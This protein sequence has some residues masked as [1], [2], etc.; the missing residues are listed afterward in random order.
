MVIKGLAAGLEG[1]HWDVQGRC[2]RALE[3]LRAPRCGHI[4]EMPIDT[5]HALKLLVCL[6]LA[7]MTHPVTFPLLNSYSGTSAGLAVA[8]PS[9]TRWL[10]S[11]RVRWGRMGTMYRSPL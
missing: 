3:R 4:G 8:V 11:Q 7:L 1:M 10:A 5:K 9:L 2:R 6:F